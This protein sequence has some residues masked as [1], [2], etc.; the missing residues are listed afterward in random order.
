MSKL[1]GSF[2]EK[3]CV[4]LEGQEAFETQVKG[5]V[6]ERNLELWSVKG[7]SQLECIKFGSTYYGTDRTETAILFNNSPEPISFVANYGRRCCG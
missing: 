7:D 1:P 2:D 3:V 4:G 6:A 5:V